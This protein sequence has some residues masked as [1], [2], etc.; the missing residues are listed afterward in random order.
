[1]VNLHLIFLGDSGIVGD[2]MLFCTNP[3]SSIPFNII[4]RWLADELPVV[5]GEMFRV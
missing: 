4:S 3:C 5:V 2:D 1:M